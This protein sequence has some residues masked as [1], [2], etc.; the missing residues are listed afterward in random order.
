[1]T[2]PF[3][4]QRGDMTA[5]S[6]SLFPETETMI[7]ARARGEEMGIA[8]PARLTAAMTRFLVELIGASSIVEVGT[9]TGVSGLYLLD[10]P[11][12]NLT[13]IDAEMAQAKAAK[14]AFEEAGIPATRYRLITGIT[15]EV[16]GKL[17]DNSYDL[18]V[19]RETSES[20]DADYLVDAL[21]Q[22]HRS[23]R[24]GGL[25]V[26]DGILGGG[27]VADPTQRDE[28]SLARREAIRA[29]RS[30]SKWRPLLLPIDD[31]VMVAIKTSNSEEN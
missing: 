30:D 17:A 20:K 12:I 7:A 21:D 24:P 10:L 26:L 1:M 23:L 19:L 11:E 16:I 3:V 8:N 5:Y 28:I 9:G 31:G 15:K 14:R 18:F 27:R 2:H 6:E 25:V 29:I 4:P 13:S 22:I